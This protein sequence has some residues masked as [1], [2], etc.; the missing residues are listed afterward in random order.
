MLSQ[1]LQ[2][3]IDALHTLSGTLPLPLF[4]FA[5]AM[6]EEVLAPIPSPLVMTLSGSLAASAGQAV[7]FLGWLALVGAV[8]KTLGSYLIYLIADKGENLVL[9]KWGKFL[10]VTHKEVEAIGKHLNHGWRDDIVLFLLR[11]I[12]I[13]PT[14]PVS[15]VAG[16]IRLNLRT[17]LVST[18]LGT[19]VRNILYLYFGYTSLG[20]LESLNEGL[21]SFESLGYVILAAL[22]AVGIGYMYLQRKKGNGLKMFDRLDKNTKSK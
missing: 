19:L 8:G 4:T 9:G 12:P 18:F 13:I 1:I 16:L 7:A 3:A 2:P 14:A 11:A 21:D 15:I 5:G 10:G 20:A 17:Y 22:M 6:I